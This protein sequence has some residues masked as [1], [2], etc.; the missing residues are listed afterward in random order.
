[1]HT[2]HRCFL[3]LVIL[4]ALFLTQV[5]AKETNAGRMRRGLP[6]LPP[7]NLFNPTRVRRATPAPS[8][9]YCS[10]IGSVNMPLEVIVPGVSSKSLGYVGPT[11]GGYYTTWWSTLY[12]G[13]GGRATH[14]AFYNVDNVNSGTYSTISISHKI[15]H[16]MAL[17]CSGPG[18]YIQRADWAWDMNSGII[19]MQWVESDGN[20]V[21][22]ILWYN[23]GSEY[24]RWYAPG[25][26]PTLS[27]DNGKHWFQG[28]LRWSCT[29]NS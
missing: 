24:F 2:F 4:C 25:Y 9:T 27:S 3:T 26:S 29:P 28:Y 13:S 5:A 18:G 23:S 8:P 14:G 6:P 10:Q 16:L 7:K 21:Y 15:T 1:M 19:S 17:D 22:P 12:S 20:S 11:T